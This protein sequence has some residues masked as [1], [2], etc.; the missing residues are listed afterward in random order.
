MSLVE[1]I[2]S[3]IRYL[4]KQQKKAI[5]LALFATVMFVIVF[6]P[7]DDLS[8]LITELIAEKSQNQVFVQFDELGV[9][10]L[11]PSIK[12]SNV[13]VDA[14]VLPAT[15][16]AGTM[17]LAPSIAGFLAFSPGFSATIEDVM[18]GDLSLSYRAGKKVN[19]NVQLQKIDLGLEKIDLKSLANF[20]S[21]PVNLGGVIS[22]QFEAQIDPNFVEQPDGEVQI[23]I[24]KFHLAEGTVPT[25]MGPILLPTM[26]LS[27]VSLRG[28]MRGAELMIDDGTIGGTGEVLNGRFKGKV[29]LRL[30]K[31]GTQVVPVWGAYEIKI[32]LSLDRT[33]EK[34]FGAFLSLYDRYKSLTGTGSR[35][36]LLLKAPNSQAIPTASSYSSF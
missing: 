5:L 27:N 28:Q 8:D 34:S 32:D 36:A 21:L 24:N 14:Q 13:E 22:A 1:N 31:Q 23:R 7:Y 16:K 20:M 18:K 10:F 26:D 30:I 4:F 15:L 2:I 25:A 12:M 3:P 6:F 35:Y 9:G 11:P 29:G 19:E 33:A 17:R